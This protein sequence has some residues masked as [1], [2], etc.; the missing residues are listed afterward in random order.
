MRE[1]YVFPLERVAVLARR[2]S[3]EAEARA[4]PSRRRR[5]HRRVGRGGHL[6]VGGRRRGRAQR[7]ALRRRRAA[8][9]PPLRC[10]RRSTLGSVDEPDV[11]QGFRDHRRIRG[12]VLREFSPKRVE[13]FD[14]ACATSPTDW[15]T[16]SRRPN[17]RPL[18]D[19]RQAVRGPCGGPLVGIPDADADRAAGW[20]FD[21]A[22]AF[23]P[24]MS[25]ELVARAERSAVE[26]QRYMDD[27]L[28]ERR[29]TR[30]TTSFRCS[31]TDEVSRR[32]RPTKSGRSPA[33]WSLPGS[34]PPPR[35]SPPASTLIAHDQLA[36]LAAT[37]TGCLGCAG[38]VAVLA[39][40]Q[41]V[42]RLAPDDMVCQDVQL[43]AGQ[44]ASANIVAACRD[45]RRYANPHE[46]DV[47]RVAGKQLSF[48]AGPTTA[49]AP[50]WP[51]WPGIAFE[52]LARRF[53]DLAC[54]ATGMSSGTTKASPASSTSTASPDGIARNALTMQPAG[55]CGRSVNRTFTGVVNYRLR[56]V[57]CRS[58]QRSS[59][60][61]SVLG[62][63]SVDGPD[64]SGRSWGE[65]AAAAAVAAGG[66]RRVDG[67]DRAVD[68][69]VVGRR[70]T[71]H[72]P[73]DG[74]SPRVEPPT[75]PG[76]AV[77][78]WRRLAPAT[79]ID[80]DRLSIDAV[81]FEAELVRGTTLAASRRRP[82]RPTCWRPPCRLWTGPP[83]ADVADQEAIRP[84]AV[85]LTEL[86]LTR[87]RAAHRRRSPGR[88]SRRRAGRARD[89]HDRPPVP[90]AAACAADAGPVPLRASGRRVASVRAHPAARWPT[91]SGL[92]PGPALRL[93]YQ[94]ILDQSD[95]LDL[96][97]ATSS[98]RRSRSAA[99]S[100][101]AGGTSGGTSSAS[102]SAGAVTVRVFRAYQASL[103]REVA[104]QSDPARRGQPARRSSNASTRRANCWPTSA[105]PHIVGLH[106]YWRDPGRR[107]RG[108]ALDARRHP[109][110]VAR[111]V[112]V[113]PAGGASPP[114]SDRFGA[115]IRPPT[116]RRA[117]RR[118]GGERAARRRRQRLPV[119]LR[120]R[121][122]SASGQRQP[123]QSSTR[124]GGR[125]PWVGGDHVRDAHWHRPAGRC[126][127]HA[128]SYQRDSPS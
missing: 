120:D 93:L 55:V 53:P 9:S 105:H 33:T 125:H 6:H 21:L 4:S 36:R 49:S 127:S 34:R 43:S 10:H 86:R 15:P 37:R 32:C 96:V 27:L 72:R 104:L 52:T 45:P 69:R 108:D 128:S 46:L 124:G 76:C 16:A 64:R 91:N 65:Q 29:P 109:R 2:A 60:R 119:R 17:V 28:G 95:E 70:S 54:L 44:V 75:E 82:R 116:G 80:P 88:S 79:G 11:R 114:R 23:F 84:E 101:R 90:R 22:R 20:A 31:S 100:P 5:H 97:V 13:R 66:G 126:C 111:A 38:S 102:G 113:A 122:T 19:V 25:P 94:Q 83:Y 87:D 110:T 73:Q 7:P 77:S 47:A 121:R 39:A 1:P 62:P 59:T 50:A 14:S 57:A 42:A 117:R 3:A 51:S 85:R 18:A 67:L 74:A 58:M 123:R 103:G 61:C 81:R 68:R 115:R 106:D 112:A 35:R 56:E 8:D 40:G 107:L 24:F 30:R 118:A 89:A 63:I 48:G 12:V 71:R 78:R 41:N 98:R 92:D 26:I 99:R